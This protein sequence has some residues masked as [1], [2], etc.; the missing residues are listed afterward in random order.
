M[1]TF[2]KIQF[3][4]SDNYASSVCPDSHKAKCEECIKFREM[5]PYCNNIRKLNRLTEIISLY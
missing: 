4:G 1:R 3:S 5:C 2:L